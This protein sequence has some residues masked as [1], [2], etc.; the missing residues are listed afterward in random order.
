MTSIVARGSPANSW[1]ALREV[2]VE[3]GRHLDDCVMAIFDDLVNEPKKAKVFRRKVVALHEK[4]EELRSAVAECVQ[5]GVTD[6]CGAWRLPWKPLLPARRLIQPTSAGS[7]TSAERR[8]TTS[9]G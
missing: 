6:L 1:L 4:Q 3:Q 2:L 7:S 9:S 5:R 8:N